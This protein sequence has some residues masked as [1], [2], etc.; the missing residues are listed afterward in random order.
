MTEDIAIY[1]DLDNLV[2]GAVEADLT[3]DINLILE[4]VEELSS[5]RIALQRAYG[6]WRQR[7][8]LTRSLAAAGF[9]LESTV[10]LG[11]NSKNLADMQMVVDAMS[12]L[13][14]GQEFD[15]YV[16][17]SGDR[18]FAPLV[19]A[20]RKRGKS[21]IGAGV[22]HTTSRRLV[23]VCDHFIFYDDL[24]SAAIGQAHDELGQ[25][26][27]R[28]LN[29]LLQ[30]KEQVPASLLKQRMMALSKGSFAHTPQGKSSFSKFLGAYPETVYLYQDGTTLFVRKPGSTGSP[31]V[32]ASN[33]RQ[34]SDD[35]IRELLGQAMSEVLS[36]REMVRASILKQRMQ[37]LSDG[38]FDETLQGDK[39]F[40]KFLDRYE[41][42]VGV[43]QEGST[44]YVCQA[45]VETGATSGPPRQ[46]LSEAEAEALIGQA[47]DELL[48]DQSRV[49]ASLLKQQMQ[50]MSNGSFDEHALGADSFRQF[51]ERYPAVVQVQQKG[52]TLL[53]QRPEEFVQPSE[54]HLRYRSTLKKHGLRVIPSEV[55]LKILQDLIMLVGHRDQLQWRQIVNRLTTYYQS[56]GQHDISKSYVNDVMRLARRANVIYVLNG[57]SLAKAPVQLQISGERQFQEAVIL[58]DATYLQEILATDSPFDLDQA[59]IALYES[60]GH[61]RYLQVVLNRYVRR[62][63]GGNGQNP[64]GEDQA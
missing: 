5:G 64:N 49:R 17:I 9:E 22:K 8:N 28:A 36:G 10:R 37:E 54:L 44:L 60:V 25:L 27:D 19:Q 58:C 24:A 18:D 55:R 50:Q 23:N 46:Y 39:T 35:E 1:L 26:L 48:V 32:V 6:D 4:R 52:T 31:Q 30:D 13:I 16:L 29:Q 45:G 62:E 11:N 20:L 47:L 43:I 15:T 61:T 63:Q 21:V 53:V 3:F 57:N 42:M 34:F 51:L 59:S 7:A 14:D 2:I 40:R 56:A 41:D 12:T 38:A 33:P